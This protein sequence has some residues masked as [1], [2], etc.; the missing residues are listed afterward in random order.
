MSR[1][2]WSRQ[3]VSSSE[4]YCVR[5]I[6]LDVLISCFYLFYEGRLGSPKTINTVR[7]KVNTF[8]TLVLVLTKLE[9]KY[10]PNS[11]LWVV[12]NP[13]QSNKLFCSHADEKF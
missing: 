13:L 5:N 6:V 7:I 12:N 11:V 4:V 1:E 3:P 8:Y 10:P 2:N 9:L